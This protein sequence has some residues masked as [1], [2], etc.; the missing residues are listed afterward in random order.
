MDVTPAERDEL[1][2]RVLQRV[3]SRTSRH[4][5]VRETAPRGRATTR[6]AAEPVQAPP[7]AGSVVIVHREST[8]DLASRWRRALPAGVDPGPIAVATEGRHTV[9]VARVADAH[10]EASRKAAADIG[11]M[12][13][14]REAR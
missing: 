11:A 9:I 1:V 7:V 6:P 5:T 13:T 2:R 4:A 8:P 3:G 10:V 14:T 12:C